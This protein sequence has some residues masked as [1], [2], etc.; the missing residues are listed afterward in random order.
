MCAAPSVAAQGTS[1]RMGGAGHVVPQVGNGSG[2][3]VAS[4]RW[5]TEGKRPP[6]LGPR[7]DPG[8]REHEERAAQVSR[9]QLITKIFTA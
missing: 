4:H 6:P 3:R 1:V 9:T 5:G 8:R 7:T 2:R